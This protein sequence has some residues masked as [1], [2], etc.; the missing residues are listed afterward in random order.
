MSEFRKRYSFSFTIGLAVCLVSLLYL[1]QWQN[2]APRVGEPAHWLPYLAPWTLLSVSILSL[3]LAITAIPVRHA[4]PLQGIVS[5]TLG[6]SVFCFATV[7]LLE[8]LCGI[9]VPDLDR[10]FPLSAT[11]HRVMLHSARPTPQSATTIL[12]FALAMLVYD[13]DS[14]WRLR[15]FQVGIVAALVIPALAA[16]GYIAHQPSWPTNG[17]CLPAIILFF[18]LGCGFFGLCDRREQLQSTVR[19]PP[20]FSRTG[21]TTSTQK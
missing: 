15:M 14:K 18:I 1:S 20:K 11:D 12:L 3:S 9:R 5:K 13:Q 17:L 16:L 2:Y 4:S 19:K 6:V 21:F 8:H 7:F 10:F